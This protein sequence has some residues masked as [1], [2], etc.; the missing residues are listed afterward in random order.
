MSG[1][2]IPATPEGLAQVL[3]RIDRR[4]EV[5]GRRLEGIDNR[6]ATLEDSLAVTVKKSRFEVHEAQVRAGF[7]RLAQGIDKVEAALIGLGRQ[8]D[9]A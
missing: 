6:L 4:L 3:D 5:I 7:E 9:R 1:V 8:R 2:T